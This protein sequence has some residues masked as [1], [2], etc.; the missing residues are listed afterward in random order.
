MSE[1][2]AVSFKI[3]GYIGDKVFCCVRDERKEIF[4]VFIA[5]RPYINLTELAGILEVSRITVKKD[6][7]LLKDKLQGLDFEFIFGKGYRLTGPANLIRNLCIKN[8]YKYIPVHISGV[9]SSN[10]EKIIH[11]LFDSAFS[12]E[13]KSDITESLYNIKKRLSLKL[14]D[15]A[16]NILYSL[17]ICF[18]MHMMPE[19]PDYFIKQSPEYSV[20]KEE[21]SKLPYDFSPS[22]ILIVADYVIGIRLYS[23]ETTHLTNW[24]QTEI[25]VKQMI[26]K[27]S[28]YADVDLLHDSVLFEFLACHIKPT[29]YRV[30]K[31]IKLDNSVFRELSIHHDPIL[32]IVRIVIKD[33]EEMLGVQFPEDEQAL[34]AYH[35]K[36]AMQRNSYKNP[37]KVL[38][39]CGFGQGSSML[40]EKS[41]KEN[42]SVD[43]VDVVPYHMLADMVKN[44]KNIDMI[45][46]TVPLKKSYDIPVARVEPLLTPEN[47]ME[48]DSLG[49]TRNKYK[50]YISD[51]IDAVKSSGA[52]FDKKVLIEELGKRF[53][54][55]LIDDIQYGVAQFD[56]Y[57]PAENVCV[58]E[59]LESWQ[60]GISICGRMLEECGAVKPEYTD[61]MIGT[62]ER[63]GSYIVVE[64]GL[65]IPH[66]SAGTNVLNF[67]V[68][69]LV[70]KSPVI[71]PGNRPVHAKMFEE[72]IVQDH[73]SSWQ[74]SIRD[75]AAPLLKK[76]FITEN[77]INAM[78]DTANELGFYMVIA[79]G[80]AM[81]H[82]RPEAGVNK[83]CVGLMK[84]NRPV[85][86]GEHEIYLIMV[87][88]A[89]DN[90]SHIG[91]I[92][93]IS[94][95]VEDEDK[96]ARIKNAKDRHEIKKIVEGGKQDA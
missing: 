11:D 48:L 43:I 40:L 5:L 17:V 2:S 33:T 49:L 61:E 42:Y 26:R 10:F 4:Q 51:L 84:L 64:E 73:A 14:S 22:H 92:S 19:T 89:E 46:S 54:T 38:V 94:E 82:A 50:I 41:I 59:E 85:M 74:E 45:V 91:L 23:F 87:L 53:G 52:Q 37:K 27:F 24:L 70:V 31:G 79:D 58:V 65:A 68:S 55:K 63:F 60:E 13:E 66:G 6:F 32:D 29:I 8:L 1:L 30:K 3:E 86:F 83:T 90:N 20:I 35:F 25:L 16:F 12:A 75:A 7:E 81:P 18:T 77:Y 72:I 21:L 80:V 39:V 67:A 9:Y 34:I 88:A 71:F 36:A 78:I 57:L 96:L 62:V 95:L 47:L 28:K 44:I 56:G 69:L 93:A 76:Q 15:E